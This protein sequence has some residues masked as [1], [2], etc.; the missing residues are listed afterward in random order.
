MGVT[1][2]ANQMLNHTSPAFLVLTKLGKPA[3]AVTLGRAADVATWMDLLRMVGSHFKV[4]QTAHVI[5]AFNVQVGKSGVGS[6]KLI[7]R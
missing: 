6:K 7:H 5:I 1:C 4:R 3:F 2:L